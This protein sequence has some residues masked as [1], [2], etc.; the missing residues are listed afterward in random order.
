MAENRYVDGRYLEENPTWHVEDARRKA[1]YVMEVIRSAMLQPRTVCDIGCG[2]GELLNIIS[3]EL[4]GPVDCDGYDISPQAVAIARSRERPGLRF[5]Q[6][7]FTGK[8]G[9][10]Y[11]LLLAIDVMEHVPDCG[12]FLRALRGK[13]VHTLFH[14]PLELNAANMVRGR[15]AD[16]RETVGHLHFFT[17]KR[18]LEKL[19][20]AGYRILRWSYT[21]EAVDAPGSWKAKMMVG[22]RKAFSA[23]APGFTALTLG[24]YS[25]LVLA[26]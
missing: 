12:G 25:L 11:D 18:A 14:I 24:G 7:D 3:R 6:E 4:P 22:P 13:G 2:G 26:E 17:R 20:G 23:V 16:K 5:F 19:E 9:A 10:R 21:P 1:G 8:D 15:L